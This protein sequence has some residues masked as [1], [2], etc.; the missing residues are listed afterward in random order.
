M[1][2]ASLTEWNRRNQPPAHSRVFFAVWPDDASAR[3]LHDVARATT[4]TCGGRVMR[5]DS[6]HLTLAFLGDIPVA[7]VPGLAR[8]A[9]DVVAPPFRLVLDRLGYWQHNRILWAGG[10]SAPLAALA[11]V[12]GAALRSAGFRLDERPYVAHMTLLRDATCASVPGLPNPVVWPVT[13]FLLV[14]SRRT[15]AGARY[16]AIGR[17]PLLG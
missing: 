8:V 16:E 17:W 13:E 3:T 2:G 10:Q 14:Q 1:H 5:Q 15:P 4:K 9:G 11:E 6:L 7:G 12:L